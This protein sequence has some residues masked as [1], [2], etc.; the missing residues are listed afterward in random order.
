METCSLIRQG[1]KAGYCDWKRSK[2]LIVGVMLGIAFYIS[3]S[4]IGASYTELV[5]LPFSRIESDLLIQLGTKGRSQAIER[6]N[7]IKLP[8]SNQAI[9]NT[10]VQA[11]AA[12]AGIQKLTPAILLWHQEKKNFI[13][14]TGVNP[15]ATENGPA[16]VLQWISKGRTIQKS[17]ETVVESHYARF[18][19]LKP[20]NTVLFG[21]REF[22]IVGI[23]KIIEGASLAA[24][25][26]YIAIDDA[27][28]LADMDEGSVN[29]LSASLQPGTDK[30]LIKKEINDL[31]PGSIV[32][33]SDSIGEM[34]QGFAKISTASTQL[35]STISLIFTILFACWLIMG[36]QEE[37]RWQVGLMQT[38]GWQKKDILLR[39]A[40]EIFTISV[41]AAIGGISVG[42]LLS[43]GIGSMEVSLTLPWNLAPNPEGMHQVSGKNSIQVPLPVIIQPFV[44]VSAFAVTCFTTVSTGV[45]ANSRLCKEGIRNTLFEQ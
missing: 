7:S 18:N 24:A 17:G 14:I 33:S 12:L 42:Y 30:E 36:K 35:L 6:G 37:Q 15:T 34:M 23:T 25:N 9:D 32:S 4:S 39:S 40:A 26:F 10:A 41:I 1:I 2:M 16:K 43:I 27:R 11:I 19:K 22:R 13:T 21:E 5:R 20:G 31:L 3:I 44:F 8:F 38:L 45:W 29:L 28:I